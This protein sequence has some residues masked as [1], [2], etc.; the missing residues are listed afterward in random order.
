MTSFAANLRRLRRA[1]KLTQEGLAHACGY[2]G[3]SRIGNYEK[4]GPDG[5]EP[6]LSEI[7]VIARALG[8]EI[9]ELFGEPAMRQGS[10]PTRLD[11]ERIA[12]LATVLAERAGVKQKHPMPWDLRDETTAARF[13]EAYEAFVAM[14]D[15]P[16]PENV[17]KFS[18]AVV[19][20][21][22]G[23]KHDERSKDVPTKGT[24]KRNVGG[25]AKR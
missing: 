18:E 9:A 23:A 6:Q 8:V 10:Q 11:P 7:P 2:S 3:Q 12:E 19:R 22:Q 16:T 17:V 14:K 25:G 4:E 20:S 24:A 13:A 5:R 1:A 21:P 15:N